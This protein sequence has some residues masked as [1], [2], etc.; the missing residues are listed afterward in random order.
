MPDI[1]A[2]G[3]Q[4]GNSCGAF[5][6][7]AVA[8]ALN[9]VP[10]SGIQKKTIDYTPDDK[11]IGTKRKTSFDP[12]SQPS[13]FAQEI[14]QLTG[15]LNEQTFQY[16]EE[17]TKLGFNSVSGLVKIAQELGL[18]CVV[19]VAKDS[20]VTNLPIYS[21]EKDL[22]KKLGGIVNETAVYKKPQSQHH[23]LI[24]VLEDNFP[25]HWIA[26]GTDLIYYDPRHNTNKTSWDIT[27]S[28]KTMS[29]YNLYDFSGLWLDLS[30]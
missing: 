12:S 21:T 22:V 11:K 15:N 30:A 9:K 16:L 18:N 13:T 17:Q 10:A 24:C 6:L 29:N 27:Q 3:Q 4:V 7:A 28:H 8:N 1:Q 26:L 19:N 5:S 20:I 25:T 14:Y 2:I 23:H